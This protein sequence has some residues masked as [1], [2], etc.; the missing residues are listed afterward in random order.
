[1]NDKIC[2]ITNTPLSRIELISVAEGTKKCMRNDSH[3]D[4]KILDTSSCPK[5][6]LDDSET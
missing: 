5:K 4:S 3:Y 1:M 6:V 2:W